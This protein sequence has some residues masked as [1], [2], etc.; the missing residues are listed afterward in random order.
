MAWKRH[1][2]HCV[3]ILG[4]KSTLTTLHAYNSYRT[5]EANCRSPIEWAIFYVY[6]L[7]CHIHAISAMPK[8]WISYFST[9]LREQW[10]HYFFFYWGE[11]TKWLH[12]SSYI[13][14]FACHVKFL[15]SLGL[16]NTHLIG[17]YHK[18]LVPTFIVF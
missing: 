3:A 18:T 1:I 13:I 16:T 8:P 7:G 11:S 12:M 4:L 14:Q 10:I 2:Y 6:Y 5:I 15:A 17:K 9:K